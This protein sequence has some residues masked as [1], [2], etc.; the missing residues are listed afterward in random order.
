MIEILAAERPEREA[1][2][3]PARGLRW[4]FRDLSERTIALAR[5]MLALG[6]EPGDRVAIW[7]DNRPDWI[8]LQFGLARIGVILVTVN[9]A[10]TQG[11]VEYLLGQSRCKAIVACEGVR[12]TE[13]LTALE[14]ILEHRAKLPELECVIVLECDPR[15][16]M[17]SMDEVVTRGASVPRERVL[18]MTAAIS[19]D[20]PANIQYTSGTTGF[21]KGVVLTHS[22]I[23]ENADAIAHVAQLEDDDRVLLQVPLFHCFG[24][25]IA[26][27]G[28]AT[29]GLP[30]IMLQKFDPLEALCA[31]QQERVTVI[32]G[33]PTMFHAILAH[34]ERPNYVTTSLRK[35]IM[36]GAMCPEPL[37]HA[38]CED[39]GARDMMIAY[40]LTEASPGVT[41]T[42]AD[43]PVE[44]RC[45]TVGRAL[46]GVEVRIVDTKTGEDVPTGEA[47]ELWCR[48]P[49]IMQGY[50]DMPEATAATITPG[51]WLRSGDLATKDEQGLVRI[52]GRIKEMIIRGGENIYPAEIEDVISGHPA[53]Y[54]AAVFAVPSDK[55][56][57]EVGVA[58]ILEPGQELT[59]EE[60]AKFLETRLAYYKRPVHVAFVEEFPLT[61][62][63]K[64]QKYRL[65]EVLGLTTCAAC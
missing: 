21:P 24:C 19:P 12:G 48:G 10:L 37:M 11:E 44:V 62:S 8:A 64:V 3:M 33:V 23:V 31:V 34:E 7:S 41:L 53:V 30:V 57:E 26:M 4:T 60:L 14:G 40:G 63:G 45:S 20:A 6:I 15:P 39:L 43:D 55:Y 52:V 2:V 18:E 17:L 9:T 28:A 42:A 5:G 47:G 38:V 51:G 29:R 56:G 22:N 13:Y 25:V 36:A 58:I 59:R 65:P 49:N 35:G 16:G 1:V 46:P 61:G 54:E 32:H 27:L 50:F